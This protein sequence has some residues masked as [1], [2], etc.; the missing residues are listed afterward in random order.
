MRRGILGAVLGMMAFL[1]MPKG[2]GL[3][4]DS[5][6]PTAP[7]GAFTIGGSRSLAPGSPM[8]FPRYHTKETYR[9]QQRK[10]KARRRARI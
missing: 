1:T 4:S 8:Y 6:A 10:A 9:S 2:N 7:F 3:T 5:F